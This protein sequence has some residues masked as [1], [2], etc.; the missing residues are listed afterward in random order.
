MTHARGIIGLLMVPLAIQFAYVTE[1]RMLGIAFQIL[2]LSS[3]G[4]AV[5][6]L[7]SSIAPNRRRIRDCLTWTM[8]T[9]PPIMPGWRV[10]F[11][12]A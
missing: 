10:R 2:F 5:A 7:W 11:G 1:S 8:T 4:F 3:G 9:N 12:V 6:V